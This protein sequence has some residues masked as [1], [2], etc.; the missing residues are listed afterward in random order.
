MGGLDDDIPVPNIPIHVYVIVGCVAVSLVSSQLLGLWLTGFKK[1]T[2]TGPVYIR[3]RTLHDKPSSSTL[4]SVGDVAIRVPPAAARRVSGERRKS[5][6]SNK[7]EEVKDIKGC[8]KAEK[9]KEGGDIKEDNETGE[10]DEGK[11]T[12]DVKEAGDAKEAEKVKETE[13]MKEKLEV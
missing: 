11:E 7:T 3:P 4:A 8:E 1:P 12:G 13:E 10:S 9:V 2:P 6:E 5:V